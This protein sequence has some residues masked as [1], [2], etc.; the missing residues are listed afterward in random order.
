[1]KYECDFVCSRKYSLIR[2]KQGSHGIVKKKRHAEI[3]VNNGNEK[4]A[5]I[6]NNDDVTS[7]QC[8]ECEQT[9]GQSKNLLNHKESVHGNTKFKC[10]QCNLEFN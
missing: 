1:M 10:E 8:E 4:R 9:F 6:E 3:N 5:K 7:I 2:H